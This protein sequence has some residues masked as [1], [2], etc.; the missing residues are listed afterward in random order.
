MLAVLEVRQVERLDGFPVMCYLPIPRL[1]DHENVSGQIPGAHRAS[2][3]MARP[4]TGNENEGKA[5]GQHLLGSADCP[6]A[7][8]LF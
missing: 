5:G 8:Q 1:F 4:A 3:H 6:H 7:H 2:S